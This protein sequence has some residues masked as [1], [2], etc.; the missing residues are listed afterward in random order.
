MTAPPAITLRAPH[1]GDY[2]W[3]VQ[4]HGVIYAREEGWDARFEGVVAGVVS[5]FIKGFDPAREAC[6]IA[7]HDGMAVGSVMLVRESDTVGRLRLLL[8]E[9]MARG[10]GVGDRLVAE[11]LGFAQRVGYA[12][13]ILWTQS[14][15]LPARR[16][17]ARA[18]FA[19][20]ES[21]PYDGFG[22]AMVSETW[23][24]K[25]SDPGQDA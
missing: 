10:L 6:W 21:W 7:E 5:D 1:P 13:V 15:L 23:R 24:L 14:T 2:G 25:F 8:V 9:P 12:E 3:I 4:R 20:E 11:C 17:Y 16:L 19:L 22:K 18:G